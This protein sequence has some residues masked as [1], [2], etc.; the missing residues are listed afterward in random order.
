MFK[1]EEEPGITLKLI[2]QLIHQFELINIIQDQLVI[3]II[4]TVS[5]ILSDPPC[6]DGY[7]L[8]TKSFV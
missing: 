1:G 7:A 6:K 2:H 5:V 8:F 4:G 3:H